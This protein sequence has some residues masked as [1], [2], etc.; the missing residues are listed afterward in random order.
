MALVHHAIA[1]CITSLSVGAPAPA[2]PPAQEAATIR[3]TVLDRANGTPL[4]DVSV[5]LQDAKLAVKTDASGRFELTGVQPGRRTL[6][7]SIVGFILVKRTL[8]VAPGQ[9][10]DL[11]I[12]L[13]EGTGTYTEEVTVTAERFPEREKA[14]P[15]QQSLG[16][17]DIQN[18]RNVLTNDPLRAIQILRALPRATISAASSP[19][20]AA[21]LRTSTSPLTASRPR[22]SST[23]SRTCRTAGP[24]R[25]ST[26]ISSTASRS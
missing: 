14:V 1:L 25:W 3:G 9:T 24:S 11:T 23:R 17:A 18:L 20:A 19:C 8:D 2:N 13:S 7:V 22:S 26:E 10:L 6:Y 15:S 21:V 5:Q 12:P 4:E 16:S